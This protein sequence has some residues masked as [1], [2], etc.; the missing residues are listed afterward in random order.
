LCLR[1]QVKSL[2][3]DLLASAGCRR[4]PWSAAEDVL[5]LRGVKQHGRRWALLEH[6]QVRSCMRA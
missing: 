5:L 4:G 1:A 3:R 6:S 2:Y